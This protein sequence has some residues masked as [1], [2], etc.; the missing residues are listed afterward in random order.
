M[1]IR[2]DFRRARSESEK[3]A[4][5]NEILDAAEALLLES[6]NERFAIAALA[7]NVGVSKST[8]FLYFANKEE[9]LLALYERAFIRTFTQLGERLEPGM[10]GRAFCEAFIDSLVDHPAMLILR[11]YLAQTIERNV[12]LESLV[13]T[14]TRLFE[15][16]SAISEKLERVME[17]E[18]GWG[19]RMLMALVNLTSG[20]V[21]A[22]SLPYIDADMLPEELA[23]FMHTASFRNIV[24]SGAEL[25]FRGATGRPFD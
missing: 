13:S 21:Q 19:M 3:E 22:D 10:S 24:L 18:P 5:R 20:A 23:D 15:H 6:G 8:I 7:D 11:A 1:A 17:L 4:R 9:L 12:A 16:G 14:K 25:I 2:E